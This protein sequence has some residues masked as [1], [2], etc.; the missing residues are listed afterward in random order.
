MRLREFRPDDLDGLAAMVADEKQMRFYPGPR[1][2]GEAGAWIGRNLSLYE[3][4]GFGFWLIE[5]RSTS[6]FL[7]YCGIRPLVLEGASMTEIGWHTKKTSWNRG[8]AT[9]AAA[10]VRDLAFAGFAQTR[11]VALVPPDHL[12]SRRVAEKIGMREGA[13]VVFDGDPYVTYVSERV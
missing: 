12:A 13:A 3:E 9:E 5:F 2:R 6:E 11:L 1:T 10:G 8:I 7:G 4:H